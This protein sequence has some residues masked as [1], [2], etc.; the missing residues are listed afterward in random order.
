MLKAWR[1]AAIL[2]VAACR[3]DATAPEAP[4]PDPVST[5]FLKDMIVSSLPAPYYH[6]EYDGAGRVSKVSFA[7]ELTNYDV[8]YTGGVLTEMQNNILVN[9]D[10][11]IYSHDNAGRVNEVRYINSAGVEFVRVHFTYDGQKLVGLSRERQ[12]ASGFVT[13]KTMSMTYGADG[14]L[15]EL[16]EHFAAIAGI[17]DDATFVDRYENYDTG[18]NVDG[19]GL[20]HDEFFDHL[21]LLPGVQL[22]KGN[23]RVLTRSGDGLNFH[24]EY[25]YTYDDHNRPLEKA[26]QLTILN[27]SNAGQV[28]QTSSVFTYY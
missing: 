20:I 27:G 18:T 19:F 10:R 11:L 9:H 25:S 24:V 12:L 26:G 13:D 23:P 6:F 7:S 15:F 1:L 17:Q 22:Q 3:R 4:V 28:I 2:F 8:K 21:V 16:T 5:V 14:N